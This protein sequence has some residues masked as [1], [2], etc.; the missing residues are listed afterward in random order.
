MIKSIKKFYFY[1]IFMVCVCVSLMGYASY[2]LI[3][4]ERAMPASQTVSG[5]SE[6]ARAKRPIGEKTPKM[7]N[8]YAAQLRELPYFQ[9]LPQRLFTAEHFF[10][11]MLF[12]GS[13]T[14]ILIMSIRL[15]IKTNTYIRR[16]IKSLAR[17]FKDV[18]RGTVRV[19]YP[20]E[21]AEFKSIFQFL[22]ES[23][24]RML[25]EQKKFEEMGLIDHLS[26]LN[27]RR[28]FEIKLRDLHEKAKTNGH[29]SVLIID[30]DYFKS[31]NDKHGHN[32][33]DALIVSFAEAL[34]KVVRQTDFI[35][36]LGGDEFCVIY[37]YAGLDQAE[38]LAQRLRRELPREVTLTKGIVHVLRWTGGLSVMTDQDKKYDDVLWRADQALLQAKEGGKNITKVYRPD[39]GSLRETG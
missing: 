31:V 17:M 36:R 19:D 37:T 14:M 25:A 30:V 39:R 9:E 38:H 7:A 1:Y 4:F 34:Q 26:Q 29:S 32:A 20:M 35:A 11:F 5:V 24:S 27:N 13:F 18:R 23:G 8:P 33:G 2:H 21:L 6:A 10:H 22:R 12:L 16:D 28:H 15:S 3:V